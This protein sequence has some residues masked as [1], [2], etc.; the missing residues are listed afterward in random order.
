ML[1][2]DYIIHRSAGTGNVASQWGVKLGSGR[3]EKGEEQ[4][5]IQVRDMRDMPN[6]TRIRIIQGTW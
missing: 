4:R 5:I 1:T 6:E 2:K 3:Q